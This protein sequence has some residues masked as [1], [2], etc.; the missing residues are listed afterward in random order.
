[1]NQPAAHRIDVHHHVLPLPDIA[2]SLRAVERDN[3][4]VLL[5]RLAGK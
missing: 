3:A 1:M 2:G 4:L 5:P